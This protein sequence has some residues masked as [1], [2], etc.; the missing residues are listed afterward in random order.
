MNNQNLHAAVGCDLINAPSGGCAV[1][2]LKAAACF[3]LSVIG[4][5]E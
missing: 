2:P 4:G 3:K 1:S 5:H